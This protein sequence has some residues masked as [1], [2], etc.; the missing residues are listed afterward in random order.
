ML[1]ARGK[2][3]AAHT[4]LIHCNADLERGMGHL[5]RALCLAEEASSRGWSVDIAGRFGD[6]AVEHVDELF[7]GQSLIQL[8]ASEPRRDLQR[9]LSERSVDV[10]HIDSYDTA[11]DGFFP[12][13]ALTSNMQDGQFG[14][15]PADLH[16]DGNLDAEL[17]YVPSG[18]A[19]LALLGASVVQIRKTMRAISHRVR[20]EAELRKRVLVVL[21]GTDPFDVTPQIVEGL[22]QLPNVSL[23]VIC[24]PE[25]QPALRRSLGDS[26]GRVNIL[27][28][29]SD[30]PRLADSMDA[31]V[32]A[33]GTS[34][35][36]FA[37]AGIPM[38]I[39]AVTENQLPGYRSCEAHGIGFP[40]GTPP[41][42]DIPNRLEAFA[43]FL[44][45][46]ARLSESAELGRTLIDGRGA[47][48]VVSAWEELLAAGAHSARVEEPVKLAARVAK[49]SDAEFLFDWRNDPVTRQVS[50][51]QEPV[52]WPDHRAWLERVVADEN[53]RLL[54]IEEAGTPVATVR[55]DRR[56]VTSW[57]ASITIAPTSR[58]RGIGKGALAAGEDWLVSA[59]P[60]QLLATIHSS[61]TA[62]QRLFRGAKYLPYLPADKDGFEMRSKWKLPT[63]GHAA[64]GDST[65]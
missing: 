62:S 60:V 52:T 1:R 53:R 47:W 28:F 15:R 9:L 39:V 46:T 49:L 25:V 32:T 42:G 20:P 27:S 51:S 61:N 19:D 11:L 45:D 14:R 13:A 7:P 17:R 44:D 22:L 37:A 56:G 54:I 12:G 24:R 50:R 38:G 2:S 21:G 65:S 6:R 26:A 4:A 3:M 34:V 64:L 23:T 33:A 41:Y 8:D 10:L 63:E 31:V 55:W 29:T 18:Q 5:M 35:W 30:L 40:L 48:R 16:V 57:E 36:D 59:E 43:D 58:G